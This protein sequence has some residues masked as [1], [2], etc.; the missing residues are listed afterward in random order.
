MQPPPVDSV[1][2]CESMKE[3]WLTKRAPDYWRGLPGQVDPEPGAP[4]ALSGLGMKLIG[5]MP[6]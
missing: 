6:W 2:L 5:A 3:W 1:K 4:A